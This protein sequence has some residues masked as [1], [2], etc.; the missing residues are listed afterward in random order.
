MDKLYK[1]ERELKEQNIFPALV[2]M[3]RIKKTKPLLDEIKRLFDNAQLKVSS[4]SP[5]G[6]E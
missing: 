5:L 6:E 4:K 3:T 2:L 1:I